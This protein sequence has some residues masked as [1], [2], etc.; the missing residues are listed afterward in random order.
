MDIYL[1][2]KVFYFFVVNGLGVCQLCLVNDGY[3]VNFI[4]GLGSVVDE[5][6]EFIFGELIVLMV[7]I[8]FYFYEFGVY[9]IVLVSEVLCIQFWIE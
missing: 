6:V 8:I 2:I 3:L 1:F 5:I 7:D 4:F 9:C